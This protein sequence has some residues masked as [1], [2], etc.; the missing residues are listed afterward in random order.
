MN[1]L[2]KI[3][4]L[5]LIYIIGIIIDSCQCQPIEPNPYFDFRSLNVE[6]SDTVL[7]GSEELILKIKMEDLN[8]MAFQP[9]DYNFLESAKACSPNLPGYKGQKIS[10][11]TIH[12]NANKPY[13]NS[14]GIYTLMNDIVQ[15]ADGDS[16]DLLN[17]I[18]DF[19]HLED[20]IFL[21]ITQ[22]P[23]VSDSFQFTVEFHKTNQE[24]A[25][26]QT[27]FIFWK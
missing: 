16:L 2:S 6:V 10:T 25:K 19:E 15:T 18:P 13:N 26:G 8:Y 9:L 5:F 14:I 4:F 12:V 20:E 24:V 11:K 7:S 1:R 27:P 22:A 23:A 3:S 21:K 17:P